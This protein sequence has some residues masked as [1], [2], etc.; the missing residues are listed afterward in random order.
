MS[1]LWLVLQQ[2]RHHRAIAHQRS[3]AGKIIKF[4]N[5]EKEWLTIEERESDDDTDFCFSPDNM[6]KV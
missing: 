2:I 4:E 6:E 1:G 5:H 3:L